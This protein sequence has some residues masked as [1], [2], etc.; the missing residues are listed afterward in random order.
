MVKQRKELLTSLRPSP[1]AARPCCAQPGAV[2]G[3]SGVIA[4]PCDSRKLL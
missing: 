2:A 4:V 1:V 3:G